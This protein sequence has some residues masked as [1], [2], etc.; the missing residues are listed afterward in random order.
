MSPT[1]H[2]AIT[3]GSQL[4]KAIYRIVTSEPVK[5]YYSTK[6]RQVPNV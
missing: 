3:L 6:T 1:A 2:T 4:A 5:H